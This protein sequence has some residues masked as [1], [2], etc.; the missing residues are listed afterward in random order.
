MSIL[1]INLCAVFMN[2]VRA[3][4]AGEQHSKCV[5][6]SCKSG[7]RVGIARAKGF[8]IPSVWRG[9]LGRFGVVSL[10]INYCFD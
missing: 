2:K 7:E 8:L 9:I 10:L 4:S 3:R 6:G 5:R 1:E